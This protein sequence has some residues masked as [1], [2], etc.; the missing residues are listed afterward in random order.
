M[1][2]RDLAV[3]AFQQRFQHQ[4]AHIAMAPARVNILGEHVDYNDGYVL[5][6][7]IDR[8]TYVA[9]SPAGQAPERS[10]LVAADF[11][12]QA[13]FT[14]DSILTKADA[15]GAALSGWAHYPA[16]VAWALSEAGLPVPAMHA[17]F[18]SNVPIAAG[19]SSS[20]S[21]EVAFGLAWSTLGVWSVPP[22]DLALLCQKAENEYVGMNCGI[23]DQFASACGV[24][25]RLLLLDCRSLAW[26]TLPVPGDIAIVIA[27]TAVRRSLT[28][29]AYNQRRRAC[30]QAV[31]ILSAELP[32]IESLRDVNVDDFNRLCGMLPQEI[33]KRARHVVEEIER[34][35]RAI[36][37]LNSGE[38]AAFGRI[39]YQCHA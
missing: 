20:A 3:Q 29:S 14:P 22:M 23:M 5:P 12:E 32:G 17:A 27:D 15:H 16:G 10:V 30:E 31:S 34:T 39:L 38:I 33:E 13:A 8:A 37:L 25:D 9:F 35:Q 18:A 11:D 19:L 21:V 36:P 6:A 2:P 24:A 4:P 7:A 26:E 1:H 28:D